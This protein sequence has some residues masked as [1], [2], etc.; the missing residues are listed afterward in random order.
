MMRLFLIASF[1]GLPQIS[2]PL[3]TSDAPVALSFVG[4][5]GADRALIAFAQRF[6]AQMKKSA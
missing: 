5:H 2:I 4:R 6:C 3:P 1:F